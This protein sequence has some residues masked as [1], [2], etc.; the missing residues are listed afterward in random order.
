MEKKCIIS[1][2]NLIKN[3]ISRVFSEETKG[4]GVGVNVGSVI[5]DIEKEIKEKEKTL[6]EEITNNKNLTTQLKQKE[7]YFEK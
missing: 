3:E 7:E 2:L 6:E 5:D 4:V 1:K